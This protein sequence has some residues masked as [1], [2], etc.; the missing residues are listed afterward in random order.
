MKELIAE[1]AHERREQFL[2]LHGLSRLAE[3]KLLWEMWKFKD[4]ESLGFESF[5]DL[6]E[7][8]IP[9][10]GLDISRSWAVQLVLTYQKYV[11]ELKLPEKTLL[12]CSPRK[13][14]FLKDEATAENTEE[15]ISRAQTM[16]LKDLQLEAKNIDTVNCKHEHGEDYIYCPDCSGWFKKDK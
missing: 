10:G 11:V 8:P 13:L 3:I 9:S 5:K 15:I 1:N 2:K 12:D 16:T 7:A 6:M 4:W 14:Y